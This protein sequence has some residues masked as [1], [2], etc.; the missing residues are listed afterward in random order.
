[1]QNPPLLSI[2]TPVYN[3]AKTIH[4]IIMCRSARRRV[5]P[6]YQPPEQVSRFGSEESLRRP[7][8]LQG[9]VLDI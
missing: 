2:L 9:H 3:E 5:K 1:M 7:C 8:I 4:E 6:I